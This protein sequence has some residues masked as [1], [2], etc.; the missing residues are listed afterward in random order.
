MKQQRGMARHERWAV[1]LLAIWV[2]LSWGMGAWSA[3]L[4]RDPLLLRQILA[5]LG[6][7]E[8][9]VEEVALFDPDQCLVQL[10]LDRQGLSGSLPPEIGQFRRLRALSLSHNQLSGPIP[11]ELGQLS[12]LE[13][14]FLD[15]NEFS[16]SIPSELGQ[17][18]NLRGL[19]LDHNQLSGPIPP[20][21]GAT[22]P[23]GKPHPAKQPPQRH[24]SRPTGPD[25]LPQGPVFGSQ[26]ALWAYSPPTGATAPPGKPLL[27]G[28]SPQRIPAPPSWLS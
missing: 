13:N 23:P 11:P 12:Q 15:Y 3:P 25:E 9:K 19:F 10:V 2:W 20:P 16:G 4:C 1:G 17:L 7:P 21:A 8:V 6:R 28:Q 18:R 14:L 27:V 22:A 24:P 5:A 26:S